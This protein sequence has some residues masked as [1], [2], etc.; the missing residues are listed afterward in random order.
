MTG[1]RTLLVRAVLAVLLLWSVSAR[2]E[3]LPAPAGPV[4]LTVYGAVTQANRG[5][6]DAF[7]D[8][9]LHQWGV[10]FER[11]AAFDRAMLEGLGMHK[12]T[13]G[14]DS[15]PGTFTFAGPRLAH[16]LAAAGAS[17][18]VVRIVGVDRY[19]VEIPVADLNR[20]DVI[21]AL[22]RDGR[23]LDLGGHGPAWI[24][25]PRDKLQPAD[26]ALFVWGVVLMEVK[27][28]R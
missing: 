26:D 16:V 6:S 7:H 17:G 14:F 13:A 18:D 5:P 10:T 12:A 1:L 23:P 4:V 3:G 8:A 24:I 20:Y 9:L 11:A 27:T 21:L 28:S 15:W 25:F 19:D 22:T 2:A